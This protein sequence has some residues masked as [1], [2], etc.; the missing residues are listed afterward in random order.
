MKDGGGEKKTGAGDKPAPH[1]TICVHVHHLRT[2]AS[3]A[4]NSAWN[5]TWLLPLEAPRL[6][7]LDSTWRLPPI[8]QPLIRLLPIRLLPS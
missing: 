8:L 5:W 7:G 6:R 3:T 1:P 4:A 2:G